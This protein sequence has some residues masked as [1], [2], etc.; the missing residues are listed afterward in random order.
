MPEV[1][2]PRFPARMARLAAD[3][4]SRAWAIHGRALALQ[5]QGRPI[6]F[7]SVGDPDFATPLSVVETAVES[8]R[9]GR[10]HYPAIAGET[11]LRRA[12]AEHHTRQ[13]GAPCSPD[14]VHV[15]PGAQNAL[16]QLLQALAGDGDEVLVGDPYYATYPGVVTAA[17]ATLRPIDTR[18]SGWMLDAAAVEAAITPRTRVLLLN[19]PAN[20][21]GAMLTAEALAAIVDVCRAHGLW[22]V[23]DEVYVDLVYRGTAPTAWTH[24]PRHD[25]IVVISSA[26]KRLAMTGFRL[27]WC[28]GPDDLIPHLKA[29][30][31]ASLFGSP[32]FTQDAVAAALETPPAE[33]ALMRDAYASRAATV[34]DALASVPGLHC[35][36]P[37]AGMFVLLDVGGLG[38]DGA[39]FAE[40]LLEQHDV[41]VM[42]GIAFG[43]AARE[44]V[45]ISLVQPEAI[46][47]EVCARIAALTAA[48][49]RHR[50]GQDTTGVAP[51]RS[52]M[53]QRA[54]RS[55]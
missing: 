22:L 11:R 15:F 27:G 25:R 33:I 29:L 46:L 39:A 52:P 55:D 3:P 16:F 13:S 6:V 5:A 8:M 19:S 26:S 24:A 20:P 36:P 41:A 31:T 23:A 37:A 49:A 38:V 1:L 7:L 50:C 9:A 18:H 44:Q 43:E 53:P 21:S 40:A 17:G 54:T 47:R 10:T 28:L 30:A 4:A 48:L 14:Q 51:T 2:P 42:P 12:I 34:L 45:R 32:P 35:S